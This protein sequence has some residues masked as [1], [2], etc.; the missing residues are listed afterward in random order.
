MTVQV[1]LHIAPRTEKCG[2]WDRFEVRQCLKSSLMSKPSWIRPR[3]GDHR[4]GGS[5][6]LRQVSRSPS[7]STNKRCPSSCL[8]HKAEIG[9]LLFLEEMEHPRPALPEQSVN[10]WTARIT[11][12]I[13]KQLRSTAIGMQFLLATQTS[14][15]R[16]LP[17]PLATRLRQRD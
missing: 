6:L 4:T 8:H 11:N 7:F 12:A 1:L 2:R 3:G 9:S 15:P 17:H 16:C 10:V 5:R 14:T 13:T